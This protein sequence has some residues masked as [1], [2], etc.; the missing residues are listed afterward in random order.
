MYPIIV[1][2]YNHIEPGEKTSCVRIPGQDP[3]CICKKYGID[4]GF[5][6]P[7]KNM[8]NDTKGLF[9]FILLQKQNFLFYKMVSCDLT[10]P[11]F[12]YKI[13]KDA[14]RGFTIC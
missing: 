9:L 1:S 5:C 12:E 3:I 14:V 4:P 6:K 13:C 11:T 10:L 8:D 2:G 7:I